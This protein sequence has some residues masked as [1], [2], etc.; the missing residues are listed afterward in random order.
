MYKQCTTNQLTTILILNTMGNVKANLRQQY[1]DNIMSTKFK[2]DDG[3]V[4]DNLTYLQSLTLDE[5]E[6][7]SNEC[8]SYEDNEDDDEATHVVVP[9]FIREI[10]FK[11]LR[12]QKALLLK[13]INICQGAN[14]LTSSE[15]ATLVKAEE[16]DGIVHLLD[17]LQDYCTDELGIDEIEVFGDLNDEGE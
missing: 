11:L 13:I 14:D 6:L 15:I 7:L 4:D 9:E 10:D 12:E 2:D 3:Y 5:L 1:I 17:A 16:L 8:D